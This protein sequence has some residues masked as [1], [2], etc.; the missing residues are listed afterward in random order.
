MRVIALGIAAAFLFCG[1]AYGQQPSFNCATAKTASARL[2]C[3]DPDLIKADADIGT[4]YRS[5]LADAKDAGDKK[6][7]AS[8][9]LTWI[10]DRNRRCGVDG[11][12]DSPVEQLITAKPC[13]LEAYK[14]QK[15]MLLTAFTGASGGS[16]H[17]LEN[18]SRA[19]AAPPA[20]LPPNELC[21][22]MNTNCVNKCRGDAACQNSCTINFNQC[23]NPPTASQTSGPWSEGL[24][25][26]NIEVRCNSFMGDG[27]AMPTGVALNTQNLL[28]AGVVLNKSMDGRMFIDIATENAMMSRLE[29]TARDFCEKEIAAGRAKRPISKEFV[30]TLIQDG[31][32]GR[33]NVWTP[34]GRTW[35]YED[36]NLLAVARDLLVQDDRRLKEQEFA[37]QR[38][39]Q[40]NQIA[41][42]KQA[43]RTKVASDLG[44][45]Q[46][47][48]VRDV[49]ANPFR[50]KGSVVAMQINFE[51]MM[52]ETE[53]VFEFG[54]GR[55]LISGVPSTLFKGNEQAILAVRISG[56]RTVKTGVGEAILPA[57]EYVGA[58]KC[59][60]FGCPEYF[61]N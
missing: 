42:Q 32:N 4:A 49:V 10:K 7:L 58:Y 44:F 15:L 25:T 40:I 37:R 50:F 31:V 38:Q 47:V 19:S 11:K 14:N 3:S 21:L 53:A 35:I 28:K 24:K 1:V 59:T 41:Q 33:T 51:R 45:Q 26:S 16:A 60:Q 27:Y 18:D 57:G 23:I 5:A 30:L 43:L 54:D 6:S 46:F 22:T 34:D 48:Y 61:D 29:K 17:G 20:T 39:A 9:Q 56:T 13:F 36:N 12:K 52:S 55:L 2:I 8:M